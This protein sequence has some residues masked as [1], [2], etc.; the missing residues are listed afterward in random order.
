MVTF[1]RPHQDK[2]RGDAPPENV[3]STCGGVR[4]P[5]LHKQSV[6]QHVLRFTWISSQAMKLINSILPAFS[7][8]LF[9]FTIPYLEKLELLALSHGL[10]MDSRSCFVLPLEAVAYSCLYPLLYLFLLLMIFLVNLF[11]LKANRLK[12]PAGLTFD[13]ST[14]YLRLFQVGL[15]IVWR[16]TSF[17]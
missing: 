15:E 6:E 4:R 7:L 9:S 10:S 17:Y 8:F 12:R 13:P 2:P 14:S 5:R 1:V 16:P 11:I 3:S